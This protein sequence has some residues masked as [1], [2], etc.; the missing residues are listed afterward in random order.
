MQVLRKSQ[1]GENVLPFPFGHLF[2]GPSRSGVRCAF[3][4]A[5]ASKEM[6]PSC[7]GKRYRARQTLESRPR[8]ACSVLRQ[9][10]TRR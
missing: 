7:T 10:E 3:I 2:S 4:A 6:V 1:R 8:G 9:R 5:L